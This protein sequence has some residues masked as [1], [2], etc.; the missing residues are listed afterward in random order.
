MFS[1]N[2]AGCLPVLDRGMIGGLRC[3]EGLFFVVAAECKKPLPGGQAGAGACIY[4]R[5]AHGA[6]GGHQVVDLGVV[7]QC[8]DAGQWV[9]AHAADVA[10]FQS[11][12]AGH[13]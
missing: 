1:H 9:V 10:D 7:S 6:A 12:I 13:A 8:V 5:L 11:G 3:G 4:L 2:L